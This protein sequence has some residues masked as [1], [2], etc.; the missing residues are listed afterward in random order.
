MSEEGFNHKT[1]HFLQREL[2]TEH[3][4]RTLR[5]DEYLNDAIINFYLAWIHND[6]PEKQKNQ[7]HIYSSHF[8]SRLK[9]T[10]KRDR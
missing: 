3:D 7:V 1:S 6:L 10:G 4:Y 9:G 8:Y 5:H 2:V